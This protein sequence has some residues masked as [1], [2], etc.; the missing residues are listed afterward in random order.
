MAPKD[1]S[2]C[3]HPAVII[4]FA[5]L[6]VGIITC[7]AGVLTIPILQ[8]IWGKPITIHK[9]TQT[10]TAIPTFTPTTILSLTPTPIT[11]PSPTV[12]ITATP[13]TVV[14]TPT[15]TPSPTPTISFD[16][17]ADTMLS[18]GQ[19]WRVDGIGLQ[20]LGHNYRL[21]QGNEC[22]AFSFD[23]T[24]ASDTDLI[25][26]IVTEQ[27]SATDNTGRTWTTNALSR[28]N[29]CAGPGSNMSQSTIQIDSGKNYTGGSTMWIISFAGPIND[30]QVTSL[31]IVVKGLSRFTGATWLINIAR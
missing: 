22:A 14:V 18:E 24:N 3:K 10:P 11:P 1:T 23:M 2:G 6:I 25:V 19:F 31:K 30:P 7:I 16:T 4:A 12:V 8:P 21:E 27:F 15:T 13:T 17:P 9:A 20:L 5:T 29:W 28:T 26:T